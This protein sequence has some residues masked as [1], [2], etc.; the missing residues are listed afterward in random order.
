MSRQRKRRS[1]NTLSLP[2]L[3]IIGGTAIFLIAMIV[4]ALTRGGG[5]NQVAQNPNIPFPEVA[6]VTLAD[7]NN[8]FQNQEAVFL[9]VRDEGSF[10]VGH[11]PGSINIPLNQLETRLS[12]LDPN[13]W[14]ITYCT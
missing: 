9:D 2:T 10:N 13:D 14:I 6:R 5:G 4:L 11:I 1:Q 12:E 8:A 7:A 3:L